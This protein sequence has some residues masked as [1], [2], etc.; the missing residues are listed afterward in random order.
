MRRW[1][2]WIAPR[3]VAASLGAAAFVAVASAATKL[4]GSEMT[5]AGYRQSTSVYVKMRDGVEIAV[6]TLLPHDLRPSERVPVLMRTTRYWRAPQIGWGLRLV[7]ALHWINPSRLIDQQRAYFNARRFAVIIV[8]ARGSG[9]SGGHRVVEFSPAE[10]ADMGEVAAWAARQPWSNGLVGTFGVSYDGNTAEL[11]AAANQQAIHAVMPLYDDF[12]S[13]A[14]IQPGGVALRGFIQQWS[15]LVA[16]LDRDDVC[17]AD[18]VKGWSCWKDR[19]LIPGVQRIDADRN[20][21]HLAQLVGEHHNL[22]V[23]DALSK[24]EFRDDLLNTE[25]GAIR[26]ADISPYG[27][28]EQIE[29][30]HVPMMV[31]CGWLD[32]NSCEG[33]LIRFRTFSN[34]QRVVIGPLSHGG[35]F[36]A[37]PFAAK[38]LPP[39]PRQEEQF[40]MEAD[41]FDDTL[42]NH[43]PPKIESSIQYYTMGEGKWHTTKTWPPEGF[44]SERLYFAEGN[45]LTSSAP[46]APAGADSYTVDFTASSGSKTRWH[47][48]LGGGDVVYPDRATED[49]KLLTYTSVPLEDDLEITGSPV[50]TLQMSS[51]ASDGA[52]HAYLE[53]VA[54]TGRVTYLDEGI[55]RVIDRKEV[56][57]TSLPYQP[58]GPAHS[59][60][61]ADAE[62]MKPGEIATIRFSLLP[63]SVLLRKGHSIRVALAG[64]DAS[65]FQR[66]PATGTP[67]WTVYRQAER[68]SFLE[69]PVKTH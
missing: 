54:P 35:S 62:A 12:D 14:L 6:T 20:G 5:P 67:A 22:N 32:A 24:V 41:F 8:D 10:V 68:P 58:L 13:Q 53:D 21:K 1:A 29:A 66:Y 38:H 3:L 64:A 63:T 27:L 52:I 26:F 61:R 16:A 19:Q 31:W 25:I 42:R 50:L 28:R 51:T 30:S 44:A 2:K 40:K 34:P 48:Q 46:A 37:D 55:F 43:T 45:T 9:A 33:A 56:D 36:T 17:G 60:L 23:A 49:K 39:V 59:F 7:V 47:T 11:A 4:P 15:N 18:E 57:P 65:L 69:L